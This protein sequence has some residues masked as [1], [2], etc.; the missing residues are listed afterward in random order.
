MG[1][2][3]IMIAGV[4]SF[5]ITVLLG[6]VLIPVLRRLKFGQTIL[7]EGPSWHKK[8]QGTP[9]MGGLMFIAG[10]GLAVVL[11]FLA[12]SLADGIALTVPE[13]VMLFG[14][15]VMALLFGLIGFWDD[16]IKV[17]KKRNLGLKAKQKLI[18]QILVTAGYLTLLTVFQSDLTVVWFPFLG[19]LDLG[20][21]YYPIMG[22][23][24]I[25][26]VNSVNLTDGLDG[27]ASSVT[28]VVAVFFLLA[29]AYL[30][31]AGL[32]LL[33]VA[34]AA[35]C[36]GFLVYNFY[37]AKVMMGDTGSMFLGGL[38]V[39]LGFG[40]DMEFILFFA[41]FIY[42]CES[43]SVILQ[44][45]SV[46]LTGKRIFKMSPIHHHFELCGWSEVKIGA[47]FSIV[48]AIMSGIG[49]LAITLSK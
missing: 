34:L 47:V 1:S 35:G 11:G 8:K 16:Y 17:V 4:A 21:L 25:G 10:I 39:A 22:I 12:L 49:F 33:A 3:S 30:R 28:F 19:S 13:I 42:C 26:I 27:L 44:V 32:N 36:V 23:L 29:T 6:R 20:W 40:A 18:L 2:F 9:T 14:G 37:P 24:I 7:E 45:L 31:I 38:V 46:K 41:G 48:T 15:V 5:V 43:L